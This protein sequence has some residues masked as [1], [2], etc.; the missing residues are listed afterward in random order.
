MKRLSVRALIET[1]KGLSVI[2]RRKNGNEYYVL[3]GG[4][5]EANENH[6]VALKRELNEELNIEADIIDLAF[7]VENEERIEY[8]YNC[9]YLSGTFTLNGEEL[10]RMSDNNYYEP[11]FIDISKINEYNIL[12]EV[13]D[14]YNKKAKVK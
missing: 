3:P 9:K 1:E 4:G 13:K 8:V 14:Y 12:E 7:E 5:I 2:Y 10:D 11:T 6:E